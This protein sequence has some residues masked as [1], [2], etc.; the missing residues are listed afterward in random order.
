LR[1]I[2]R[3]HRRGLA[4]RLGGGHLGVGDPRLLLGVGGQLLGLAM[5][6]LGGGAGGVRGFGGQLPGFG[7]T[8]VRLCHE[9]LRPSLRLLGVVLG[10]LRLLLGLGLPLLELLV[11]PGLHGGALL[12]DPLVGGSASLGDVLLDATLQLTL[13]L[14]DLRAAALGDLAGVLGA[15]PRLLGRSDGFVLGLPRTLGG[16][17]S[18][19][20][21][22]LDR[23][24]HRGGVLDGRLDP[25]GCVAGSFSGPGALGREQLREQPGCVG[26]QLPQAGAG[27][28]GQPVQWT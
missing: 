1:R 11:S 16:R 15:L 17:A 10:G 23:V 18:S 3:G 28:V 25:P 12:P 20:H 9:L 21:A 24:A 5:R 27:A 8:L 19:L 22:G 14:G 4:D 2:L 13:E 7:E 6:L 26:G